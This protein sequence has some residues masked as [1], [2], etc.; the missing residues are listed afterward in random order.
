MNFQSRLW[1]K[2]R[3]VNPFSTYLGCDP[4][5][6][7]DHRWM[8]EWMKKRILLKI[9]AILKVWPVKI[10]DINESSFLHCIA[11]NSSTGTR[12]TKSQ[13]WNVRWGLPVF[14]GG[15]PI[16]HRRYVGASTATAGHDQLSFR[17]AHVAAPMGV[18][19]R[20]TG[21]LHRIGKFLTLQLWLYYKIITEK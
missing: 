21:R 3:R 11:F 2:S 10:D 5:R 18:W 12:V 19:G 20:K 8:G 15:K 16:H 14:W 4:N 17:S 6:N 13:R 7:Y 9:L 1:R